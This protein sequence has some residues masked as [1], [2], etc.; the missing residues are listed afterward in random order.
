M[1]LFTNWLFQWY[2]L[3]KRCAQ[4]RPQ[5]V[6]KFTMSYLFRNNLV[7]ELYGFIIPRPSMGAVNQPRGRRAA[8]WGIP[9][10]SLEEQFRYK[11]VALVIIPDASDAYI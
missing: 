8:G 11:L 5:I 7:F 3:E 2:N 9:R 1:E 10:E 6:S 4:F